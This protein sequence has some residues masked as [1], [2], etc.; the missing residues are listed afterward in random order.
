MDYKFKPGDVVCLRSDTKYKFTVSSIYE[1]DS[2][3]EL[4][5]HY[6]HDVKV[7]WFSK[8]N[9]EFM[10]KDL[11]CFLLMLAPDNSITTTHTDGLEQ[12]DAE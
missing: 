4:G 2:D 11:E 9:D 3:E 1:F 6:T 7:R 8:K 10:E 5:E 12:G